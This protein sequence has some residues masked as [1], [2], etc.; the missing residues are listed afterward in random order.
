MLELIEKA[1]G[2]LIYGLSFKNPSFAQF[3]F[4]KQAIWR[5]L[6]KHL[7]VKWAFYILSLKSMR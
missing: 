5:L 3:Y 6:Y 1:R 2:L 7:L 4:S